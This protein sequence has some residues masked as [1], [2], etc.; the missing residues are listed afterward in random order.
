MAGRMKGFLLRERSRQD[1]MGI[2]DET[3]SPPKLLGYVRETKTKYSKMKVPP[4]QKV[5]AAEGAGHGFGENSV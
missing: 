2:F 4:T 1:V 3:A 5:I